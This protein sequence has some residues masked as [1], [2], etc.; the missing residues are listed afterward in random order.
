MTNIGSFSTKDAGALRQQLAI[1]EQRVNALELSSLRSNRSAEFYQLLLKSDP[2][3]ADVIAVEDSAAE[4]RKKAVTVDSL[5]ATSPDVVSLTPAANQQN[6]AIAGRTRS[7]VCLASP[8]DSAWIGGV[9]DGA[10]GDVLII[11]NASASGLVWLTQEDPA[12]TA[13]NRFTLGRD[14]VF[15]L[16]GDSAMFVYNSTAARWRMIGE[17][18]NKRSP[19]E[20]AQLI[21]P[22][23]G[24]TANCM[25]YGAAGVDA[26]LS[27]N[28]A[29][30]SPTNSFDEA[31]NMQVTNSTGGGSA[32][33][34][35]SALCFMRG[36]SVGRQGIFFNSRVRFTALGA[37]GGVAVGLT[38]STAAITTQPQATNNTILLCANGGQTTLRISVR[39]GSAGTPIDLGAN[40]PVPSA[41]AAYEVAFLSMPTVSNVRYMVRRLDSD[42]RAQGTVTSN[43]PAG[44][45][46]L[47]PRLAVMVGATAVAN[48]AQAT[49]LLARYVS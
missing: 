1:L 27:T 42:Q 35:S 25:G 47:G 26:T 7:T 46:L 40:F 2:A 13:A 39:D 31:P 5:P 34:R 20:K 29:T 41:T 11:Q 6:W 10:S 49:H 28:A 3:A 14:S 45:T 8:A 17:T 30:P 15:L 22:N 9:S 21:V 18:Q 43:L 16:P 12:S 38:N 19:S 44:S 33:V 24:A 48:T 36:L 4:W 23:S 37:S 32:A